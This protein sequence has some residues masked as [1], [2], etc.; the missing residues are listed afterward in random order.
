MNVNREEFLN[1]LEMVR[2]GL[3]QREFIEQSSCFV[4]QDEWVMTFNDEVACRMKVGVSITGAVQSAALLDMLGKLDDPFLTLSENEAGEMEFRGKKK[5]FAL[6][7]EAEVFLPISRVEMP[8]KWRPLPKE[9]VEA[10]GL[11]KNCVSTDESKF[12]LTCIHVHPAFIE[13]CDNYQIMRCD[14]SLGLKESFLVRG[15]SLQDITSLGMTEVS[16]TKN[17]V[18]F[19]NAAGLI[20]SC[21]RYSE[22]YPDLSHLLQSKGHPITI[23]KGL[24]KAAERAG[25]LAVDAAGESQVQVTLV[26]GKIRIRGEGASGWYREASKVSYDG[27]D[28]HFLISPTLLKQIAENHSDAEVSERKLVVRGGT[29]TYT[30]VLSPPKSKEEEPA[31]EAVEEAPKKKSKKHTEE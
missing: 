14:V 9:F 8:E 27:P 15:T 13:A 30:T 1:C 7:R 12:L 26:T 22:N 6:T 16:L 29:W 11:T 24:S 18:H 2:A 19:R 4:F 5:T 28:L 20:Y 17:W 21:R 10:V 3:S 25:V 23:P 31:E